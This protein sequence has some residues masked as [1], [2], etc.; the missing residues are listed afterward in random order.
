MNISH[1]HCFK[2]S[3]VY[4]PRRYRLQFF[5]VYFIDQ[6]FFT[7]QIMLL[8]SQNFAYL[9]YIIPSTWQLIRYRINVLPVFLVQHQIFRFY[10]SRKKDSV[11]ENIVPYEKN[12]SARDKTI[13]ILCNFSSIVLSS[14]N[15]IRNLSY[16]ENIFPIWI[17]QKNE[18]CKWRGAIFFYIF[19]AAKPFFSRISWKANEKFACQQRI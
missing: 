5:T 19:P 15:Y 10:C 14:K 18:I 13:R 17:K 2:H 11:W 8:G 9:K 3:K 7:D 12:L 4:N 6:N 16:L 1:Y